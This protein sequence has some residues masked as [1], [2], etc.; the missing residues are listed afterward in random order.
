MT[1]TITGKS[2]VPSL[3]FA[4]STTPR[5]AHEAPRSF[6]RRSDH[7]RTGTGSPTARSPETELEAEP[8]MESAVDKSRIETIVSPPSKPAFAATVFTAG[9]ARIAVG[10]ETP[11]ANTPANSRMAR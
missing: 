3:V 6:H 8:D 1:P 2:N 10:S 5:G 4:V 7:E 9:A 11:P